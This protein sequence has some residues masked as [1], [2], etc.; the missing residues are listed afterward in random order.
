MSPDGRPREKT[1]CKGSRGFFT[2]PSGNRE[3]NEANEVKAYDRRS[4]PVTCLIQLTFCVPKQ[5]PSSILE[6]LIIDKNLYERNKIDFLVK[7][8]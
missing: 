4:L 3:S 8:N 1:T 6:K 2:K 7:F 5:P